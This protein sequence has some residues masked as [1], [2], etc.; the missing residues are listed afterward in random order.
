M[1]GL[2]DL[3]LLLSLLS[4]TAA[5][6]LA[7]GTSISER[8]TQRQVTPRALLSIEACSATDD[9]AEFALVQSGTDS[10]KANSLWT[11]LEVI[12]RLS[13]I[14]D[15]TSAIIS[16]VRLACWDK[17]NTMY[18][19]R[20]LKFFDTYSHDPR[21]WDWLGEAMYL[22]YRYEGTK[23]LLLSD[24]QAKSQAYLAK[25][26]PGSTEWLKRLSMLRV[27]LMSSA[28]A[29]SEQRA[30]FQQWEALYETWRIRESV[31]LGEPS[32]PIPVSEVAKKWLV[33]G[34]M[35]ESQVYRSIDIMLFASDATIRKL[36]SVA[37]QQ[38]LDSAQD[39]GDTTLA[40]TIQRD[41]KIRASPFSLR[42]ANL[43]GGDSIDTRDYQ[44]QII[45]FDYWN[46]H[47]SSCMEAWPRLK[48]I[49]EKFRSKGV[50]FIGVQVDWPEDDLS[51][52]RVQ[53]RR[54][55]ARA[56]MTWP[57]MEFTLKEA[58]ARNGFLGFPMLVVID[59]DGRV[60]ELGLDITDL[61]QVLTNTIAKHIDKGPSRKSINPNKASLR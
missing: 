46:I 28:Q 12:D 47:C 60:V 10:D 9:C 21:R 59:R 27:A 15:D 11:E 25:H 22:A 33:W 18:Q 58:E 2:R 51:E 26:E 13:R 16:G 52:S 49:E 6:L 1:T 17:I 34:R 19:E 24:H 32:I 41:I 44:S 5:R 23:V 50:K 36:D 37:I 48:S 45:V 56:S 61:D 7:D 30:N 54:L 53:A 3:L 57:Q 14:C 4:P 42:G 39:L 43:Y 35:P 55:L 20:G 29:T 38:F 40:R 8:T 31:F